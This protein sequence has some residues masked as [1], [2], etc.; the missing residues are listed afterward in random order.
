MFPLLSQTYRF[1]VEVLNSDTES[2][3]YALSPMEQKLDWKWSKDNELEV[4]GKELS[5]KLT[6]R[7]NAAKGIY[8]FDFL[9]AEWAGKGNFCLTRDFII[10][11]RCGEGSF[12]NF[13]QCEFRIN[14]CIWD[15]DKCEVVVEVFNKHPLWC[16]LDEKRG[17]NLLNADGNVYLKRFGRLEREKCYYD[18]IYEF[19]PG[20][21]YPLEASL[22]PEEFLLLPPAYQDIPNGVTI[23][24][25]LKWTEIKTN[26]LVTATS[27]GD[28]GGQVEVDIQG[29]RIE[30]YWYRI[31]SSVEPPDLDHW[32]VVPGGWAKAPDT[33]AELA[34]D[35][36]TNAPNW[37]RKR[38]IYE[39]GTFLFYRR[40]PPETWGYENGR[41]LEQI[42]DMFIGFTNCL[43]MLIKSNFFNINPAGD[44]PDNEAY[45][46]AAYLFDTWKLAF[47]QITDTAYPPM[48]EA[49]D[50]FNTGEEATVAKITFLQ[51]L[52]DLKK[53]FNLGFGFDEDTQTI[54]IE[55]ISFFKYERRIDLTSEQLV[56][57]IR[58]GHKF[59]YDTENLPAV[60]KFGWSQDFS[61]TFGME[62]NY[63]GACTGGSISESN[64]YTERLYSDL[65]YI[66]Q[67]YEEF[68]D[69]DGIFMAL[70]DENGFLVEQNDTV[71]VNDYLSF[72]YLSILHYWERPLI[73][74][75]LDET[76]VTFKTAVKNRKQV[77]FS[78]PI[79]CEDVAN[80]KP[81]ILVK[82]Q[83]GW[84][85]IDDVTISDPP[86]EMKLNLIFN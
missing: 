71:R 66:S 26:Y 45:A 13:H 6:F 83:M 22:T 81:D 25:A 34:Y 77:P 24:P 82:T 33:T 31:F 29:Y 76:Y 50:V 80:F 69:S 75:Y 46:L 44:T 4:W 19:D 84:G 35:F 42:L 85:E 60:E 49:G 9:K 65:R 8:D 20:A 28:Q 2:G 43:G 64:L 41:Y 30:T 48:Y 5:T 12:E 18:V 15:F 23:D 78:F 56:K 7:N 17:S 62:I 67:K 79:C 51:F 86:R 63:Y 58:G 74:G 52:T 21:P 10:Q 68:Q 1:Y 53:V 55:H 61:T 11:R 39:G 16:I 47:W 40:T 27:S 54:I 14:K 73:E 38:P 32:T 36:E 70:V 59:S 3:F 37:Q 72:P 57:Y